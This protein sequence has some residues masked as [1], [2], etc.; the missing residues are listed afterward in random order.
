MD[1]EKR[2]VLAIVLMLA[3]VFAVN[4]LF[5]PARPPQPEV[6]PDTAVAQQEV[7]PPTV[8]RVPQPELPEMVQ[9]EPAVRAL[10]PA[11]EPV[12]EDTA[13]VT[14]PLY[15][16]GFAQRGARLASAEMLQFESLADE[17]KG[18]PVQLVPAGTENFLS[19]QWVIGDD[20]VDLRGV[21]FEFQTRELQLAEGG[22][23]RPLRLTYQHPRSPFRVELT[24]TFHPDSFTVHLEG[25]L[26]GVPGTGWWQ[27]GLGAGLQS[28]EWNPEQDYRANLAFVGGG[29]EGVQ[30]L[31]IGDVEPGERATLDGPFDWVAVRTKYFVAALALP[32]EMASE[33]RFGGL[34]IAGSPD[35]YRAQGIASFPVSRDGGFRYHVYIGPQDPGKLAAAGPELDRVV[36]YGYKW[37]QPILRPLAAAITAILVWSHNVLG[38]GYGWVLILFGIG[39]RVVLFPLYQKSMRS[40]MAMM[41]VQ[42]LMKEIQEKYKNDPQKLQQEMMKVYKEEKVNPL[43]GCLPMLLPFPILIALFFVFRDT[44]EFRG[45]P[46]LWLP[47]LSQADP[48]YI[49]PVL[50]GLSLFLM[51]WLGQRSMPSVNPQMKMMMWIMP[52]M[53]VVLFLKF[54]SGLNL[55]Y[56][57][58]NLAS[59]PQQLYLNKER[60]KMSGKSQTSGKKT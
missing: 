32:L 6:G 44:I 38:L 12:E 43:G 21:H 22:A 2:L 53:L 26:G 31:K 33:A 24:Y 13:W 45:V 25:R 17:T 5:P 57:T 48:L 60:R 35:P 30:S 29:P 14:G 15:R 49:I 28:N 3:T 50:M 19:H 18:E 4:L 46:F 51:Q 9:E 55:Y 34:M 1:T 36:P 59:I 10:A 20:T 8:E 52:V 42:P 58:M 47:D 16:L 40:Q 23:A 39:I 41:R 56:A 54:A 37:L 7:T 27:L 11:A